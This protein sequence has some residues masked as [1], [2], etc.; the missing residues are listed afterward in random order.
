MVAI[1]RYEALLASLPRGAAIVLAL[2]SDWRGA[3]KVETASFRN[4]LRFVFKG[5]H[6]SPSYCKYTGVLTAPKSF[7]SLAS[8]LL[9]NSVQLRDGLRNPQKHPKTDSQAPGTNA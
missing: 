8:E 3:P 2:G 9:L 1:K 5:C 4:F 7:N 6:P